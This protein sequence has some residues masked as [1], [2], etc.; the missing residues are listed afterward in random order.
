VPALLVGR[1]AAPT[2]SSSGVPFETVRDYL[3]SLPGLPVD[4]AA[5]LR[6]FTGDGSVLPL[7]V[8]ADEL[9]TSSADVNGVAATVLAARDR[10]MAAVVWVDNG[11][12]TAVVGA[13]DADEVLTVARGLR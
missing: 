6:S 4:V 10:T 13:L 11:V 9:T 8:N 5:Q 1:A 2:A 12:A 7:P 3:L